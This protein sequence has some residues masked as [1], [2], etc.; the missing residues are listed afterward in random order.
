[1]EELLKKPFVE[2]LKSLKYKKSLGIFL[3]EFLKKI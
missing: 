3:E 2:I 1:M